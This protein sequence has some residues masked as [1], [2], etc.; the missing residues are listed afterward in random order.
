MSK[1]S[2]TCPQEQFEE[3][4]V[5]NFAKFSFSFGPWAKLFLN[6]AGERHRGELSENFNTSND[7]LKR[8]FWRFR[9]FVD[10]KNKTWVRHRALSLRVCC[11]TVTEVFVYGTF[12]RYMPCLAKTAL[13][14]TK[15]FTYK[16]IEET[17][18]FRKKNSFKETKESLSRVT[19]LLHETPTKNRLF[20][21]S[22]RRK[23]PQKTKLKSL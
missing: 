4:F 14:C 13:A 6:K 1:F 2:F 9:K 3:T 23:I 20:F 15:M 5:W 17:V 10:S 12:C 19:F 21:Q 11:P 18:W 7:K 22:R 16:K 8:P